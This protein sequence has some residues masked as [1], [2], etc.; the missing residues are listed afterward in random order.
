MWTDL[1]FAGHG[2]W[3]DPDGSYRVLYAS[4]TPFGVYLEKLAQFRPDLELLATCATIRETGRSARKW[5]SAGALPSG[6]RAR[7][8]LGKGL[9]DGVSQPLVAVARARSLATLRVA[10][11]GVARSLDI[12]EVDAGV[13]RLDLSVKFLRFT[14]AISRF[15]YEQARNDTPCFAGI[16]YLS[17]HA[18]DVANCAVFER[19]GLFPVTHLERSS[20]EID[21]EDFLKACALHGIT[22]S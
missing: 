8:T 4:T 6:W 2:R 10:L 16:F 19:D 3:D 14:Q 22:P 9:T 20:V 5:A 12:T 13:I 21:D 15:I 7:Y 1:K 17:Q 18:D 11:A